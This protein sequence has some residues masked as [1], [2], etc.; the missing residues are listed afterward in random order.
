MSFQKKK[1]L[2]VVSKHPYSLK[3]RMGLLNEL[4]L[5]YDISIAIPDKNNFNT[6]LDDEFEIIRYSLTRNYIGIPYD[7]I[8]LF[9]L[10]NKIRKKKFTAILNFSTKPVFLFSFICNF[11]NSN[12]MII[13]TFTGLGR[14]FQLGISKYFY[15]IIFNICFSQK[16]F[17]IFQ[18]KNNYLKLINYFPKSLNPVFVNGSGISITSE[19]INLEKKKDFCFI[20]RL[21]EDKGIFEL[22]S[23]FKSLLNKKKIKKIDI[24]G[25]LDFKKK[26]NEN[27]F[28]NLLKKNDNIS[29]IG[30]IND[31]KN[32]V[33]NYKFLILP[34]YHEGIPKVVL[35]AMAA[36]TLTILTKWDGVENL[37]DKFNDK[38]LIKIDN[39]LSDNI[40]KKILELERLSDEEYRLIS[41]HYFNKVKFHYSYEM[42]SKTYF[43]VL[44]I[45]K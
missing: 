33:K 9:F 35:D 4:K 36:K 26:K 14:F 6:S 23:S 13:N 2:I 25:P 38:L 22:I 34:S 3:N 42:I 20:G 30:E 37:I 29:Y 43:K 41:N 28:N 17:F 44:N 15:K 39:K 8:S 40:T 24:A 1:I 7:I 10:Y 27:L 12:L 16:N 19:N 45:D 5:F 11:H 32:F 31:V 18:N 21:N